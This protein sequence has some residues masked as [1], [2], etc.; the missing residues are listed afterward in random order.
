MKYFQ[1]NHRYKLYSQGFH[2]I[3]EFRWNNRNDRVLFLELKKIFTEQYGPDKD[4]EFL[5]NNLGVWKYNN[6]WR[7]EHN[8][9]A[10][11]IR[12]YLKEESAMSLA[13]LKIG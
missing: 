1:S 2:H 8:T 7:A 6:N 11:R 5:H 12:I 4:K 3:A 13:M 9:S 10:K